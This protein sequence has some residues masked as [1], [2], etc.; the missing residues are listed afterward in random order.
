MKRTLIW[1][2]VMGF[3]TSANGA[4][5]RPVVATDVQCTDCVG[6]SDI[7]SNAVGP[8]EIVNGSV[9]DAKL[10]QALRDRIAG[11]ESQ[12]T[13]LQAQPTALQVKANGVCFGAFAQTV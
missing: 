4:V 10:T 11:L 13:A 12:V 3:A 1:L 2:F 7:A 5:P 8:T 9:S 6:A